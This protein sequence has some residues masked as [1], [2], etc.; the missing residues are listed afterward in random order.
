MV[1]WFITFSVDRAGVLSA[2]S[3]ATIWNEIT[4]LALVRV[5]SLL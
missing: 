2:V 4:G 1:V 3:P 5:T